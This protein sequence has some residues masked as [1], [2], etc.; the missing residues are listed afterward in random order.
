MK[1]TYLLSAVALALSLYA[2]P[3]LAAKEAS[4]PKQSCCEKAKANG[5]E[6]GRKC[7]MSAKRNGKTCDRCKPQAAATKAAPKQNK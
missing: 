7:C 2:T 5:K 3:V 1:L 6:C 4:A